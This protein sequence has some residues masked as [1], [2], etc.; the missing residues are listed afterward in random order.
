MKI[1]VTMIKLLLPKKKINLFY[2]INHKLFIMRISRISNC[3]EIIKKNFQKQIQNFS[4]HFSFLNMQFYFEFYTETRLVF[5]KI[6]NYVF[7]TYK[8]TKN[9]KFE[10]KLL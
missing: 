3:I 8:M 9:N 1:N 10:K 6:L 4:N 7:A 5:K 2:Y